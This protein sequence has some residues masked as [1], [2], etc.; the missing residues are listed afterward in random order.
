MSETVKED[1]C[2]K[3][4]EAGYGQVHFPA[5]DMLRDGP[6]NETMDD[7]SHE[8]GYYHGWIAFPQFTGPHAFLQEVSELGMAMDKIVVREPF[9]VLRTVRE[10]HGH[11]L[12][13]VLV[14]VLE[15]DELFDESPYFLPGCGGR[16]EYFIVPDPFK[17]GKRVSQDRSVQL[18]LVLEVIVDHGGID[19]RGLRHLPHRST[20]ETSSG[21]NNPS[22]SED[23]RAGAWS[24]SR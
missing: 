7:H 8:A 10:L 23:R 17:G 14:P 15:P 6:H 3:F 4:A 13:E 2:Y 21:E 1:I 19:A 11:D 12:P 5:G 16:S 20:F 24:G 9:I 18:V 22:S